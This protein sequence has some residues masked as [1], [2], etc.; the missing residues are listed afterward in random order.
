MASLSTTRAQ[1]GKSCPTRQ[2]LKQGQEVSWQHLGLDWP[3][4]PRHK[5]LPSREQKGA[6]GGCLASHSASCL[7]GPSPLAKGPFAQLTFCWRTC[8]SQE[9]LSSHP[10]TGMAEVCGAGWFS[11]Q[12]PQTGWEGLGASWK[13]PIGLGLEMRHYVHISQGGCPCP[14]WPCSGHAPGMALVPGTKGGG[15]IC[16]QKPCQV[17]DGLSADPLGKGLVARLAW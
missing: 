2:Q 17:G 16:G 13:S 15:K 9:P 11:P 6:W 7:P 14:K 4:W 3:C 12:S 1:G 10:P 8:R 5:Q